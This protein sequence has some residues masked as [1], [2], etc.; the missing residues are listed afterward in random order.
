M[1]NCDL[2]A[3]GGGAHKA[4]PLGNGHRGVR[5]RAPVARM[6]FHYLVCEFIIRGFNYISSVRRK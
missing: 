1:P 3:S 2:S 4:F 6:E 5:E